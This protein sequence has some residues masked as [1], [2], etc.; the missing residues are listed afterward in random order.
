[1]PTPSTAPLAGSLT[2]AA[3]AE[4][5]G[6]VKADELGDADRKRLTQTG[7]LLPIIRGWYAL[8]RD[9]IS[10]SNPA[11]QNAILW[12]FLRR[13]LPERFADR[14]VL[15]P[16]SSLDVLSAKDSFPL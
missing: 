12:P 1:M 8:V 10:S 5:D 13:Y 16:E 2:R 3:E 7:H 15:G 14:Y 11:L 9:G 6:I 4:V